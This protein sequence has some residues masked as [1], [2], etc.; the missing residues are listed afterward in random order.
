MLEKHFRHS[1]LILVG[2]ILTSALLA[3]GTFPYA[4][5]APSGAALATPTLNLAL[6]ATGA[7]M[8][9]LPAPANPL[10]PV[11]SGTEFA[12]MQPAIQ[13]SRRLTLEWPP[14]IRAGDADTVRLTLEVDDR[15]NLTPTAEIEG[16]I[17]RGQ[18]VFIPNVYD[19]HNV[20]A[21]ARL[22]L[23]GLQVVPSE[24]ASQPLRPGQRVTFYWSVRPLEAGKFRGVVWFYLR[25][26]PLLGGP[27][28]ERAISAQTIEIEAV[29]FLG[30]KAGPARL[31]GAAGA[32]LCSV[33]G[34]PFL[35]DSLRWLLKRII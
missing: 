2:F 8:T 30:L 27:E 6:A 1:T 12:N 22:D 18:T 7:P 20:V 24:T 33:L 4:A 3:C 34:L 5:Q 19:T 23:A 17:T 21:E 15:G 35:E 26:V 28:S 14:V 9:S 32:F 29:S 25:F 10:P 31:L 11:P 16:H 13:E